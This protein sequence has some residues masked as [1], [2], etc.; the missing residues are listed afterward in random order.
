MLA[1]AGFSP[2]VLFPIGVLTVITDSVTNVNTTSALCTGVVLDD[3][4]NLVTAKGF[5]WSI[6]HNPTLTT[7]IGSTYNGNGLGGFTDT[8]SGLSEVT[9]YYVRAYATNGTTTAYGEERAFTTSFTDTRDTTIYA[10]VVI[11][12]QYWMAE[13]LN[14][15]TRV[16]GAEQQSNNTTIEKY[17]YDDDSLKCE[18]YGAL[19]QWNEMMNYTTTEGLQGI[20]PEG[21]RLP[22]D[23]DWC[24]LEQEVDATIEC[25]ST[26]WRGTDG[27]GKLKESGYKHWNSP[28]TGAT[29]SS[30]FTALPNGD[31]WNNGS[32]DYLQKYG[33]FWTSS[34]DGASNAWCRHLGYQGK[35]MDRTSRSKSDGFGVRCLKG[36]LPTLTTTM[37]TEIEETSATS[38][39]NITDDAGQEIIARGVCWG[40]FQNPT[41]VDGNF[42][43]DGEGT[44]EF[45]SN[46]EGLEQA[47]TY[48]LRAWAI[49]SAGTAYGNQYE[50]T[51]SL[52]CGNTLVDK[53]DGQEYATVQIGGQCWMK[54]N[55][56]VGTR[57]DS[58]NNQTN[59][60]TVEK[61]CYDNDATNCDEYGGLYQW[62]EMMIY[63]NS[64]GVQ[65]ICP[66]GWHL[67]TDDE[68][69]ILEN[70]VEQG[71]N[72]DF[73]GY[74]GTDGGNKLKET[75]T[76]HWNAANGTNSSGFTAFGNGKSNPY[77]TFENLKEYAF[78]WSSTK[79][80]ATHAFSRALFN[81]NGTVYRGNSDMLYGYGV[82]CVQGSF[83]S[84]ST[85]EV[86]VLTDTT[87]Q[88][89]GNVTDNG[90]MDLLE[91][92]VCWSTSGTPT[93]ENHKT[94]CGSEVGSF[95]GIM[96]GLIAGETY[97]VRAYA[98]NSAG[99]AYGEQRDFTIPLSML[100]CGKSFIDSRDGKTYPTVQIGDQCWMAENL[101][102]GDYLQTGTYQS[103]TIQKIEKYCY[104]NQQDSCAVY[105]G[106]YQ[107]GEMMNYSTTE[108]A[109]GI[110][111]V[112]WHIPAQIEWVTL[113]D[114]SGGIVAGKHL[115]ESGLR[116]WGVDEGD[117]SSGFSARGNGR[118][119]HDEGFAWIRIHGF[120]WSSTTQNYDFRKAF[121]LKHDEDHTKWDGNY[122]RYNAFG[123]RCV[124]SKAPTVSTLNVFDITNTTAM[125][126]GKLSNNTED[127]E[128]RGFC[129]STSE[130][131]TLADNIIENG[132]VED[133]FTSEI[134]GL[135][136]GATYHLRAYATNDA[137]TSYGGDWVFKYSHCGNQFRDARDEQIYGSVEIG[138]Q[139]WMQQN[140]N[141]GTKINGSENQTN[142]NIIQKY[143]YD[144]DTLKCAEYGGLYQWYEMMQY[145][146]TP[147][148]QGICPSGWFLPTDADWCTLEQAV[149]ATI[150]CNS[151]GF[152]GYNGGK[153]LKESGDYHWNA[154]NTGTNQFGFT[155][156][157]NGKRNLDGNFNSLKWSGNW[158][159]ST[160]NS[161]SDA[162]TRYLQH[163]NDK[164]YRAFDNVLSGYSVRCLKGNI[165]T[166]KTTAITN[167]TDNT[168]SS[169]GYQIDSGRIVIRECGVCWSKSPNPTIANSHTSNGAGTGSFVSE[170]TGLEPNTTYY[171]RA[172]ATNDVGTG[173]GQQLEFK[174]FGCGSS[175][176]DSRDGQQYA[177]VLIGE[178]CWMAENLN[179]GTKING[180]QAQT[181]NNSIEK[182]C[183]YDS[184]DKCLEYGGL[185]Q[186]NEMMQYTTS[187]SVQGICPPGWR[188]PSHAEWTTLTTSVSNQQAYT[189]NSNPN[190]IAKA[191]AAKTNWNPNDGTCVV[192]N[193]LSTNNATGFTAIPGGR[194]YS[195]GNFYDLLNHGI[196]W[197]SSQNYEDTATA[198]RRAFSYNNALVASGRLN[199]AE[200]FAVRCL[201]GNLPTVTT[202]SASNITTNS[203]PLEAML[204]TTVEMK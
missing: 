182:Y 143:C 195:N 196:W 136:P 139:C 25:R 20:C 170:I 94:S 41:L 137:G 68:W 180:S 167:I 118:Y 96:N 190:Y 181:N 51:T 186:W 108:G 33:G 107:W 17:C 46:I 115:K 10:V 82:R 192:G 117:N 54:E 112:G 77:I 87:A 23:A 116:Y 35:N 40:E 72:C 114:N 168:A 27:G 93:I 150:T 138:E 129:W 19:Y 73:T 164:A 65:G 47:T 188:L 81:G 55:L 38:G 105:G 106:L 63:Q 92:G 126:R 141:V 177:T 198:W 22:T 101:N 53:R 76:A 12:N 74:R 144:N 6:E 131:P 179:Y 57:I 135:I 155:A 174:S 71:I 43:T 67:P 178:Q 172:Y 80:S 3:G 11:G 45:S 159:A 193:T 123:V 88:G 113:K 28:N 5:V 133:I 58:W 109:Q 24:I 62:G 184:E 16:N 29:N 200:G 104:T 156:R 44:G 98:T 102:V 66:T 185:Y 4:G 95:T 171:V 18:E 201:M 42:T 203:A 110:C 163:D 121:T 202:T 61:Y 75:G 78:F 119:Y 146:S 157:G 175:M 9:T 140:L 194:R 103:Q 162:C 100:T 165:P 149:D 189:C 30:G 120:F 69:C 84:V 124:R 132:T 83:P 56:N 14:I 125:A 154:G 111:P 49:S 183:Y 89:G 79:G 13:N 158:W 169:G 204:V 134:T 142:N 197:T 52:I 199:K 86:K 37:V 148:Q 26:G 85:S 50:F 99:T 48:Y 34:M 21:W 39:G 127:I 32:F 176:T 8:I 70:F 122:H 130:N 191:M 60:G 166:L 161:S 31:R 187:E 145:Q 173:Y 36:I 90:R 147:G 59:T 160:R 64:E 152:R 128:A 91:R 153:K 1:D 7:N 97:Y 151:T 2:E 15:G